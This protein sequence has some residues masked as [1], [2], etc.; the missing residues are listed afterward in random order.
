MAWSKV[1]K[2]PIQ[3]GRR[4]VRRAQR[5]RQN[6]AEQEISGTGCEG[7][8][9]SPTTGGGAPWKTGAIHELGYGDGMVAALGKSRAA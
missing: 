2:M 7:K 6:W 3:A 9:R 1:T 5:S 4:E 8:G